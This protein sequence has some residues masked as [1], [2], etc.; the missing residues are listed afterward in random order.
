MPINQESSLLIPM[1][2]SATTV[3]QMHLPPPPPPKKKKKKK[4]HFQKAVGGVRNAS[5]VIQVEWKWH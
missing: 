5:V 1:H 4:K 3:S 2:N